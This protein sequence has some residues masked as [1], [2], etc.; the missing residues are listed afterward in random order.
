MTKDKPAPAPQP[1][2]TYSPGL[3]KIEFIPE[4][5]DAPIRLEDAEGNRV[6]QCSGIS[7]CLTDAQCRANALRLK[8]CWNT[9]DSMLMACRMQLEV[10]Q[11]RNAWPADDATVAL[12]TAIAMATG[13]NAPELARPHVLIE[14]CGGVAETTLKTAGAGTPE[15][16]V[17]DWDEINACPKG[18]HAAVPAWVFDFVYARDAQHENSSDGDTLRRAVGKAVL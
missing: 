10:I 18:D 3:L 9:H 7:L 15:V 13:G 16:V 1:T 2:A 14:V 5:P 4:R 12:H 6:A 17:L 11:G 8:H